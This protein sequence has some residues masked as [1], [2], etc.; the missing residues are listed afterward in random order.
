MKFLIGYLAAQQ[1]LV[2]RLSSPRFGV[3][4]YRLRAPENCPLPY[5]VVTPIGGNPDYAL[6]GEIA[7]LARVVQ[8]DVYAA[9]PDEAEEIFDLIRLAPLSGYRGLMGETY[10]H[11]VT[12]A[13]E[14]LLDDYRGDG[15]DRAYARASGDFRIHYDRP[16][17]P[18]S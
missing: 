13:R 12:I 3:K 6:A 9:T 1:P 15:S 7:D 16:V 11:A 4:L 10:V 18:S 14:A 8:V 17:V 5:V 2:E